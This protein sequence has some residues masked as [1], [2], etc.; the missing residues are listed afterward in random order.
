MG[1]W[2]RF[3]PHP[4]ARAG[5]VRTGRE[6]VSGHH[7]ASRALGASLLIPVP[8]RGTSR[9]PDS[10][11][12]LLLEGESMLLSFPVICS[13]RPWEE[14][15]RPLLRRRQNAGAQRA[16]R[17]A[18]VRC[19][20]VVQNYTPRVRLRVRLPRGPGSRAGHPVVGVA[21]G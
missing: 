6:P 15:P 5:V 7:Q 4:S 17:R 11:S 2:V 16:V 21:C 3:R 10:R 13:Q 19:F 12:V 20:I 18:G 1:Q 8:G 9:I 14:P